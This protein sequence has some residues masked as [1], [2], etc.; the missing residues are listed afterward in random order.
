MDPRVARSRALYL[1]IVLCNAAAMYGA[2]AFV[3]GPLTE[4]LVATAIAGLLLARSAILVSMPAIVRNAHW[5]LL[6]PIIFWELGGLAGYGAGLFDSPD[7]RINTGALYA[8]L[9]AGCLAAYWASRGGEE[10]MP[11]TSRGFFLFAR[12]HYDDYSARRHLCAFFALAFLVSAALTLLFHRSPTSELHVFFARTKLFLIAMGVSMLVT[13]LQVNP[14]RGLSFLHF[15]F[16]ALFVGALAHAIVPAVDWP[17]A[18]VGVGAGLPFCGLTTALL[19]HVPPKQRLAAML[20]AGVLIVVGALLGYAVHILPLD[21]WSLA[22][23]SLLAFGLFLWLYFREF[24]EFI[25]EWVHWPMYR[26][27]SYGPGRYLVPTRGPVLVI[28]NHAAYFDP[29]FIAK[30]LPLRLRAWMISTMFDK[31]FLKWLAG[32]VYGAI[33]VP[34]R[35]GFRR[36]MP[37]IDQAIDALKRG[38]NMMIFPEAWLRRK[39][40]QPIHRFAQGIYH[41]LKA[42]PGVVILPAWIEDSWGSYLSFKNGPPTKGK[43]FDWFYKIRMGFGEPFVLAPELLEDHNSTRKYL[44][45]R[46]LHC[47]S[48]LSLPPHPMPGLTSADEDKETG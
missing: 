46:V 6:R 45:E 7:I 43:T 40:E 11:I 44:M 37:E 5:L 27:Y 26:F 1:L 20:I 31:P 10:R 42:C 41:I 13:M 14:E 24:A 15:G 39:E 36:H 18:L 19:M 16:F 2:A 3:L 33:R 23:V 4:P 9:I 21:A 29:L 17:A 8:G 34:D 30:V 35:P 22:V 48:Y 28:A 25:Q 32:D 38:E 12:G 47:R